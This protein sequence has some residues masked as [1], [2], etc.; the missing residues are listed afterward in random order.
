MRTASSSAKAGGYGRDWDY[1]RK[2][3]FNVTSDAALA[4]KVVAQSSSEVVRMPYQTAQAIVTA[5][6]NGLTQTEI[7][8][9]VSIIGF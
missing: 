8:P 3:G 1:L 4:L 7:S 9:I 6:K 5:L 2:S